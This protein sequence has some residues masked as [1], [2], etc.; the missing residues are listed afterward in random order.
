MMTY[1][2]SN[3]RYLRLKNDMTQEDLAMKLGKKSYTT[4]QKWESGVAEPPIKIAAQIADI[5]DVSIDALTNTDLQYGDPDPEDHYYLNDETREMAQFL[6]DNPGHRVLLD[7]SRDLRPEDLEF[8]MQ[9]INR[10]KSQ[11]S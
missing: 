2:A 3:I 5:F 9:M 10:M 1:L 7:A 8:V 6:F 4:I 11:E